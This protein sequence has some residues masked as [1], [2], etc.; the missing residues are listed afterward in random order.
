[1]TDRKSTSGYAFFLN[2]APISSAS[3]KQQTVAL[4]TAEAEYVAL[5]AA[6]Q[7]ALW[8]R[9]LLEELGLHQEQPTLLLQ[10]NQSAIA[11]AK[12]PEF[13]ARTKHIDIRHH[14]VRDAVEDKMIH[15]KFCP[16]EEMVADALTKP[17]PKTS[18]QEL[19]AR[20]GVH[21]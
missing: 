18:F 15:L 14:F 8:L 6:T 16:T 17:L 21:S 19:R 2:G 1:V 3:R 7:E 12:N 11:I 5:A 9:A 10:D 13:H 20:L 4:S